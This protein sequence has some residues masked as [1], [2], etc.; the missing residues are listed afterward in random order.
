MS[1]STKKY[2]KLAHFGQTW[3]SLACFS[4]G[5]VLASHVSLA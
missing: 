5:K 3:F 4:P 2:P 1:P